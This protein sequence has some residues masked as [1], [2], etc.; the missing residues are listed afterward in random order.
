MGKNLKPMKNNFAFIL[1]KIHQAK[2]IVKFLETELAWYACKHNEM[3]EAFECYCQHREGIGYKKSD[4]DD[5]KD[6]IRCGFYETKR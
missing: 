2:E 1:E 3:D 6:C 5:R 4:F